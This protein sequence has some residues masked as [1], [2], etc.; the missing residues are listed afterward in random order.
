MELLKLLFYPDKKA[1]LRKSFC[2][3]SID[4]FEEVYEYYLEK[5]FSLTSSKRRGGQAI[6]LLRE[7]PELK[8]YP[9]MSVCSMFSNSW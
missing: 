8:E 6:G 9:G 4:F 5:P 3:L 1:S 7:F 2:F